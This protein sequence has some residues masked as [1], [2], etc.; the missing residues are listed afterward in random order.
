MRKINNVP[1]EAHTDLSNVTGGEVLKWDDDNTMMVWELQDGT[2]YMPPTWNGER[3]LCAGGA[4]SEK[5]RIQYITIATTGNSTDFGDLV[6]GREN[7][8][9]LSNGSRGVFAGGEYDLTME[10]V[11][12]STTGN[13]TDFGDLTG[14]FASPRYDVKGCCNGTRGLWTAGRYGV[15]D[16]PIVYIT[17][18]STGDAVDFGDLS[19]D[20]QSMGA[21]ADSTRAC[22]V[23]GQSATGPVV[24]S[25]RIDYVAFN[26][27]G[28]ATDFG[29]LTNGRRALAGVSDTTRA[30]IG[31]GDTNATGISTID[32]FTIQTTGNATDFGDRTADRMYGSGDCSNGTRGVFMGGAGESYHNVMD[33][34]TIQTASNAIDF[35]DLLGTQGYCAGLG[36][37]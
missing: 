22:F 35:G 27:T 29:N 17:V 6:T 32:Y 1:V 28:D 10:Y 2:D 4:L 8:G 23:G 36:G 15:A 5:D 21:V 13:T 19:E 33:Y 20:R 14:D 16:S 34:I 25:D 7:L 30:V 3:G 18:A 9:G 26:T 24:M 12:I 11:T 37:D 31:D